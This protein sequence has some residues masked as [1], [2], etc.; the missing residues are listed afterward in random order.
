M[1]FG[2]QHPQSIIINVSINYTLTL[3]TVPSP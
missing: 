2:K 3:I 1:L